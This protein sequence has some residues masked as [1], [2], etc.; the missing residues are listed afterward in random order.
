MSEPH[1]VPVLLVHAGPGAGRV[2]PLTGDRLVLGRDPACAFPFD[3][4]GVSREHCAFVRD[5]T[6]WSIRDLGSRNGTRLNDRPLASEDIILSE[7]DRLVCGTV[8]LEFALD[9]GGADRVR[10]VQG[11]LAGRALP[12]RSSIAVLGRAASDAD[13]ALNDHAASRQNTELRFIDGLWTVRDLGSRNGTDYDGAR[14]PAEVVV[15][16]HSGARLRIGASTVDF[17]DRRVEDLANHVLFGYRLE[18]RVA[19]GPGAVIYRG[20]G[21]DGSLVALKILDPGRAC[22]TIALARFITSG[23]AQTRWQHGHLVPT[24]AAERDDEHAVVISAWIGG[25]CLSAR[26]AGGQ[27]LPVEIVL[28]WAID[29]AHGLEAAADHDQPHRALRPGNC[30]IADD[31][32]VLISDAACATVYDPHQPHGPVPP[33]YLAPEELTGSEPTALGNQF[34]LGCILH[35][36]LSARAPFGAPDRGTVAQSRLTQTLPTIDGLSADVTKVL[37]RL[38]A[39]QAADR[40]PSWAEVIADLEAVRSGK[41]PQTGLLPPGRS[42][43]TGGGTARG[44]TAA[45]SSTRAVHRSERTDDSGTEAIPA[46]PARAPTRP[47]GDQVVIPKWAW[48]GGIAFIVVVVA[49]GFGLPAL[50]RSTPSPEA[51][52]STSTPPPRAAP[53]APTVSTPT[54][55]RSPATTVPAATAPVPADVAAYPAVVH[56]SLLLLRP[57]QWESAT[58]ID[59]QGE[60]RSGDV[61]LDGNVLSL[62]SAGTTTVLP[63]MQV[64]AV[65]FTPPQDPDAQQGDARFASRRYQ[66]AAEAYRAA[67]VRHPNHPHLRQRV[68]Q[69]QERAEHIQAARD[70]LPAAIAEGDHR[71]VLDR[72]TTYIDLADPRRLEPAWREAMLLAWND[73]RTDAAPTDSQRWRQAAARTG[74]ILDT[75]SIAVTLPSPADPIADVSPEPSASPA[76]YATSVAPPSVPQPAPT[77][78]APPA[79]V[80]SASVSTPTTLAAATVAF[81]SGPAP[82]MD[83]TFRAIGRIGGPGAQYIRSV[84]IDGTT[85]WGSGDGFTVRV[86]LASGRATLEGTPVDDTA[87]WNARA[88]T[89]PKDTVQ[90]TDPRNGQTYAITTK[91]VHPILQQPLLTSSAGWKMWGWSHSDVAEGTKGVRWG[92]LMADSRGYDVWLMP[93]GR[94]GVLCWTDGGNSVLTRDPRD[95]NTANVVVEQ[96]GER[97]S[98]GG[99][100]TLFMLIDPSDGSP[101]SGT[102]VRSHVTPRT[103]DAWG[104]VILPRALDGAKPLAPSASD[105]GGGITVLDSDLRRTVVNL[106]IGG[107]TANGK[108]EFGV[109]A[110]HDR[111]LVLGGTTAADLP[112]LGGGAKR[113]A[114]DGQDAF[115]CVLRLW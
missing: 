72:L 100:A 11:P 47:T 5:D 105:A 26:L 50:N 92:P 63:P 88:I 52:R 83:P 56:S 18:E 94:I 115:F 91:Q 112:A 9:R 48:Q 41:G 102:F 43:L 1:Q 37:A 38:L 39:R 4:A 13:V 96:G 73:Q 34:S 20:R 25:G 24:L 49:I 15:P 65:R 90:V 66:E 35:H 51:D 27:P 81:A 21:G 29:I 36:A 67:L 71:A 109:L 82:K 110:V 54:A 103:I 57:G 16:L 95:L 77:T 19:A 23:R 75:G 68:A 87:A 45:R 76:P 44:A 98:S 32:K 17:L 33:H 62:R 89:H 14:L 86:D 55:P 99:M 74:L 10:V 78:T 108:E 59:A 111:W 85:A 42:V 60:E 80:V 22:N 28:D 8:E 93:Q 2:L 46:R 107:G 6:G 40:Y 106:R 114:D 3:A 101:V 79:T 53:P 97:G 104:R 64:H 113:M 12:L 7:G 84:G 31:G 30:L 69:A 61:R 70:A 58:V